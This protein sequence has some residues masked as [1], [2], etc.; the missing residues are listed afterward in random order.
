LSAEPIGEASAAAVTKLWGCV[1]M[2]VIGSSLPD[3]GGL[4]VVPTTLPKR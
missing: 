4:G 2:L 3:T 1:I